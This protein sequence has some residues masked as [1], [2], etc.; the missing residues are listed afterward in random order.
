MIHGPGCPVCVT[1]LEIIDKALAIAARPGRDLL[2]LRRHAAGAG[3]QPGPVPGQE[4]RRRRPRRLLPARRAQARPGEPRPAGGVLRHRLR[5][6]RAGQRDDGLPGQAARASTNF[7][8]LVSHVLVPPAIAAIMESPD[9][10]GAGVPR[11][12][13]R[14]QR[15]GHR[16]STRRSPSGTASRSW[17]PASSR[18][19]SSRASGAPCIQLEEGRH[20]VENAYPRAV[21]AEGN[22][23]GDG[24]AARTSSRSTDRTWRGIGMIPQSGW[25]LSE[26][27]R[28]F[29]A[30][31][32]LRRSATSTPQESP[33]CRVGRGAA[34]ADQAARVRGVRHGVHAAQPARRHDGLRPR[35]PA[36]RTTST[37]GSELRGGDPWLSRDARPRSAE[38]SDRLRGLGL[39]AAAARHPDD[40]DGARRRRRDVGRAGRAPLP[41][42]VRRRRAGAELGD[43]AVLDGR[44]A[45]RL[46][47]STDSFVVQAAVLPRRLHRRPRRQRHRQRPGDVGRARRSYLSTAFILEEGTALAD[48][49]RVADGASARRREAAGVQLVTGDTKVVD[50]G[51]GDGVYV[52]TAGIGVVAAG[53]RHPA[54]AGP[55]PG[56]VVIVSGDIGV[57]GVAVMSCREGLEF[58]TEVEQ[59]H[60]AAAR[61]GRGDARAP[62]P[63][64]TCCATRPAAAWRPRSTRSPGPPGSGIE[65]VERDLP[66]P[67]EV[68]DACGAARPR[69]AVRRQRGQ[70]ARV[71]AAGRTPTRC[72]RRCG[73]TRSGGGAAVIG[74]LRRRPPRHGRRPG[75]GS[76][77]P[78]SSTC[79]S[80]SSS[81][82]S[83]DTDAGS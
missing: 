5:D 9:L 21:P 22:P 39:P 78:G 37:A 69:P 70:A 2:L 4:R 31:H 75:P 3:Q 49:G 83:A 26:R 73:R 56:D 23:A 33:I 45:R 12:R 54:A 46:A 28:D 77:A 40:R 27:Y 71:R 34:G 53:R 65:L 72:S 52:N 63:T 43:S 17:S 68:R 74:D 66:I 32:A 30:E 67:A 10:P 8:L 29:D 38:R 76:A 20:E 48:I 24:D 1:P 50:A 42:G 55:R 19:T 16:A 11:R 64:C 81:P 59:R 7:S 35:A 79:R 51:H 80:A 36:R 44:P 82:G 57:H 15:D 14:L 6:H 60:R 18:S 25:R 61:P 62:A 58:G 41:A 47:F 13:A